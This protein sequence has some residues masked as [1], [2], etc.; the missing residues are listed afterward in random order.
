MSVASAL[1][2]GGATAKFYPLRFSFCEN[3]QSALP[4]VALQYH[5][6]ELRIT[7]GTSADSHSWNV[8]ANYA[9]LDPD[10]REALSTGSQTLPVSLTHLTLPLSLQLL[11]VFSCHLL[12][13]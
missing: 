13:S 4:L 1:Y 5:D 12:V 11:H 3:W 10:E 6:V 9:Y 8:Y 2:D 7:W